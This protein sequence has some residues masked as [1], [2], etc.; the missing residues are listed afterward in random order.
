MRW[1]G[2]A[3]ELESRGLRVELSGPEGVYLTLGRGAGSSVGRLVT[4][5]SHV[6]PG[7]AA[8]RPMVGAELSRRARRPKGLAAIGAA[9]TAGLAAIWYAVAPRQVTV[10][11]P[12]IRAELHSD[13]G[14]W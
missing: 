3:D 2:A 4:R 7:T 12:A 6:Q 14:Y 11:F 13:G 1:G 5:S 8:L 10:H 9:V